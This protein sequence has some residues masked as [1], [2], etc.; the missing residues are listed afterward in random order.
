[1]CIAWFE[2]VCE[3]CTLNNH[4]RIFVVK[5]VTNP[6]TCFQVK[7]PVDFYLSSWVDFA[8]LAGPFIDKSVTIF[9]LILVYV[10]LLHLYK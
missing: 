4:R 2:R 7:V 5:A 1:M 10:V 6:C 8:V 9:E 3:K